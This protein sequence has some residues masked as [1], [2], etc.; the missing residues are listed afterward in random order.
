MNKKAF[1][2]WLDTREF[3]QVL[4]S[5]ELRDVCVG[6]AETI[7]SKNSAF[8]VSGYTGKGRTGAD[9]YDTSFEYDNKL[10]K[11]VR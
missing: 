8:M 6:V 5:E 2:V 11:A 9:V 3:G 7:A 4:R 1:K 10:L